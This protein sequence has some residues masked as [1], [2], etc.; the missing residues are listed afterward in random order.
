MLVARDEYFVVL[1][2]AD[3]Y[4]KSYP[5]SLEIQ[6]LK[7]TLLL[8]HVHRI[9]EVTELIEALAPAYDFDPRFVGAIVTYESSFRTA[10]EGPV[11]EKGLLQIS[12]IASQEIYARWGVDVRG[13][14]AYDPV[15]NLEAAML[16]LSWLSDLL[17]GDLAKVVTAYNTG[18]SSV[19]A[20]EVSPAT[21]A[22]TSR[23]LNAYARAQQGLFFEIWDFY[24]EIAVTTLRLLNLVGI[25]G[26]S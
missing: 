12:L 14:V 1:R 10:V 4:L 22:Y 7:L 16:Y 20:G 17:D 19:L 2:A 9:E 21:Q 18:V 6:W 5:N 13:L 26:R 3:R 24:R 25:G 15:T 8:D 11:Y 23:I